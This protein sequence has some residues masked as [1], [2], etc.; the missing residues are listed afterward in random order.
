MPARRSILRLAAASVAALAA[1]AGLHLV[2][3]GR[4]AMTRAEEQI[5]MPPYDLVDRIGV[6]EVRQ[7]GPRLAA[8][9]S[10]TG[11]MRGTGQYSAFMALADFIFANN[12]ADSQE[13][14]AMTAP[15]AMQSEPIAM[16]APVAMQPADGD[17]DGDAA[18]PATG[19]GAGEGEGEGEGMVMRFF[20]PSK[21]TMETLPKPGDDRVRII[22]VPAQTLAVLRFSG[23]PS[24]DDIVNQQNRLLQG[25]A[26][27]DWN[28]IGAPGWFGYDAPGTPPEERRNEVFVEVAP[29]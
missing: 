25:V 2:P 10:M 16:T 20:M 5:E 24:A 22:E 17:G 23:E 3:G 19:A 18:A 14:I 13:P 28:A 15:V 26:T 1:G 12:R 4:I 9:T 6:I 21:Y 7:Y 29:R 27:S 11:P 8:E